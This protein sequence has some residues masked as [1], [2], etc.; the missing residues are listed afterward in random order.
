MDYFIVTTDSK[1]FEKD[2]EQ[3]SSMTVAEISKYGLLV[4]TDIDKF[5][6]DT[7]ILL[8]TIAIGKVADQLTKKAEPKKLMVFL[9]KTAFRL[10]NDKLFKSGVTDAA[11]SAFETMITVAQAHGYGAFNQTI[12]QMQLPLLPMEIS[13]IDTYLEGITDLLATIQE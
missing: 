13:P 1:L 3:L 10:Q 11:V 7:L 12:R 5:E 9:S 4:S 2:D 6:D 8:T